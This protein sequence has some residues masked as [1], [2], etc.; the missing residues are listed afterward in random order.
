MRSRP[1]VVG[2][3]KVCLLKFEPGLAQAFFAAGLLRLAQITLQHVFSDRFREKQR[4][5]ATGHVAIEG[6]CDAA[7]ELSVALGSLPPHIKMSPYRTLHHANVH[8]RPF[9]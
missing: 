8:D 4:A 2:S 5:L 7:A 9:T 6:F 1:R 3:S